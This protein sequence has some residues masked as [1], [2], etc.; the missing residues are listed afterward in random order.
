MSLTG[1][2]QLYKQEVNVVNTFKAEQLGTVGITRFGDLYRYAWN[3]AVALVAGKTLNTLAKVSNHTTVTVSAAAAIGVTTVSATLGATAAT[4]DQYAEGT[5]IVKDS[6]G[7]GQSLAIS[8]NTVT[9]S[10]GVITVQLAEPLVIALTTSSVVSLLPNPWSSV[11]VA[12]AAAAEVCPGVPQLAV[13]ASTTTVQQYF[14]A[15]TKG[16]A[17]VLSDGVIG[18]GSGAIQSASV[19]GAAVVEGTSAVTQRLGWA[20]EATIDTKYD[21]LF[22]NID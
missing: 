20:P 4:Q 21:P 1:F 2:K 5:L 17:S 22:L 16:L 18:K 13:A 15:K 11:I 9:A 6:T 8:G 3:G 10:A 7:V 19:I 14:W 12:P